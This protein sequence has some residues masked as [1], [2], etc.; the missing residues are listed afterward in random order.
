MAAPARRTS[1]AFLSPPA[2]SDSHASL[3]PNAGRAASAGSPEKADEHGQLL[4]EETVRASHPH[5]RSETRQGTSRQ[6]RCS[7]GLLQLGGAL[8]TVGARSGVGKRG[9]REERADP[10]PPPQTWG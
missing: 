1:S 7:G 8:S 2:E 9:R 3:Q 6:S 10:T 5:S 4:L